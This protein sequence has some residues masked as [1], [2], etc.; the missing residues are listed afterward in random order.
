V[1]AAGRRPSPSTNGSTAKEEVAGGRPSP[2]TNGSTSI[3]MLD[4]GNAGYK[5][6]LLRVREE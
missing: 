1:E 3:T 6:L 2:L 4:T 5:D